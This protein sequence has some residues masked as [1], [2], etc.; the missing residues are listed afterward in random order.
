MGQEKAN[1]EL[2]SKL[3]KLIKELD[4]EQYR[5]GLRATYRKVANKIRGDAVQ[6]L[7]SKG[8]HVRGNKAD[9][10]KGIRPRVYSRSGGFMVTVKPRQK[11]NKSMHENRQG[12]LK[13][14]LYWLDDGTAERRTKTQTKVF[15]RARRGHRTGRIRAANI[16]KPAEDKARGYVVPEIEKTLE[17]KLTQQAKKAGIEI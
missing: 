12:L 7:N 17:K 4:P 1:N 6:S 13:P 15:R 8:F 10:A 9:W 5:K 14:V 11:G 16:L 3:H 2:S